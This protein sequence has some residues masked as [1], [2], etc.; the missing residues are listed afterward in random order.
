MIL[1]VLFGLELKLENLGA[2][3]ENKAAVNL[4]LRKN[5]SLKGEDRSA[6]FINVL[7]RDP[8]VYPE[9]SIFPRVAWG[10]RISRSV[11]IPYRLHFLG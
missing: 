10:C 3:L 2:V 11:C 5:L 8:M 7:R 6:R 1:A 4:W 9:I